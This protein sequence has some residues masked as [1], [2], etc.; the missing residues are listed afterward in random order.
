MNWSNSC[1]AEAKKVGFIK[2]LFSISS[3]KTALAGGIHG[4]FN[5]NII[6]WRIVYGLL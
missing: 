1:E 4:T 5:E 6:L 2:I 3:W